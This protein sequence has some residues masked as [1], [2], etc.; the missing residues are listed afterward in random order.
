MQELKPWG[1]DR[2]A[3]LAALKDFDPRA[4]DGG[5][6]ADR[7]RIDRALAAREPERLTRADLAVLVYPPSPLRKVPQLVTYLTQQGHYA[8]RPVRR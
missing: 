2:D 6:V 3:Q 1:R 5:L 7:L 8:A 4:E